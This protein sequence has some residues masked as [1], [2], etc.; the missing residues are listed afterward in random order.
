[1]ALFIETSFSLEMN[2]N[3]NILSSKTLPLQK[4]S[5][6]VELLARK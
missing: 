2:E 4:V 6:L 5:P 3:K 1:M